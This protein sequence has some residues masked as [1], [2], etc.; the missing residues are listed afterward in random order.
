LVLTKFGALGCAPCKAM[1]R[2]QTLEK[3][4]EKHPNVEIKKYNTADE[5]WNPPRG[6]P[7]A[8]ADKLANRRKVTALP[9]LIFEA[10]D[11]EELVRHEGGLSLRDL[12]RM[13]LDALDEISPNGGD[14]DD[15]DDDGN[16]E[17]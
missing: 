14:D 1:E 6:S 4:V 9:T 16:D 13:Y 3:F 15:G 17:D 7:F 5:D 2:A 10:A 11:G 8:D 12:E